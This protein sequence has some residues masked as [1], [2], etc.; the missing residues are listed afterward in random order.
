MSLMVYCYRHDED[1]RAYD[2][3][4]IRRIS[5]RLDLKTS[6]RIISGRGLF[7]EFI[8]HENIYAADSG[9]AIYFS[10]TD[11]TED[12]RTRNFPD[13]QFRDGIRYSLR[14]DA[15]QVCLA[16]DL[17][18]SV[19]LWYLT[20]E[21]GL[22]VSSSM[23]LLAMASGV[24]QP[25]HE[26]FKW[27]L[28]NGQLCPGKS[29]HEGANLLPGGGRLSYAFHQRK[30]QVTAEVGHVPRRKATLKDIEQA[31]SQ[32]IACVKVTPGMRLSLSGG[33]DSRVVLYEFIRRGIKMPC[34][35]VGDPEYMQYPNCDCGIARE[36][37]RHT[38]VDLLPLELPD[39]I[40]GLE[41]DDLYQHF[42]RYVASLEGCGFTPPFRVDANQRMRNAG[43]THLIRGTEAF[44]WLFAANHLQARQIVAINLFSD[45]RESEPLRDQLAE[46]MP[47]DLPPSLMRRNGETPAAW[48]DRLYRVYRVPCFLNP[49]DSALATRMNTLHPFVYNSVIR[50]VV[51]RLSDRDRTDKELFKKYCVNLE[52]EV[53][54]RNLPF[55]DGKPFPLQDDQAKHDAL[56][57]VALHALRKSACAATMYEPELIEALLRIARQ[58]QVKPQEC[59]TARLSQMP[60][61]FK[62][63]IPK[64]LRYKL[65]TWVGIQPS[66]DVD[67]TFQYGWILVR[68]AVI[69]ITVDMLTEDAKVFSKEFRAP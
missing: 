11:L 29:W 50:S 65:K 40:S 15:E 66:R 62:R 28:G 59:N 56:V 34:V 45:Y 42:R 60:N 53:I 33:V 14:E 63:H 35:V 38:G 48:R 20:N 57:H 5:D 16:N 64:P 18:G 51:L 32:A 54:G 67:L 39:T 10:D 12:I 61:F 31:V 26:A 3:A 55:A 4:W 58:R 19:N 44:G 41:Q 17:I 21:A 13:I 36:I 8:C 2:A 30:I 49:M 68:M 37:A 27:F 43:I 23:R 52:R 69:C 24:Y 7:M 47:H 46:R 22:I 9:E 25:D 1:Y 6:P